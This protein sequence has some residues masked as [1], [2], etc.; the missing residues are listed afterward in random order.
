MKILFFILFF[1]NFAHSK[2]GELSYC[3]GPPQPIAPGPCDTSDLAKCSKTQCLVIESCKGKICFSK[4]RVDKIRLPN[5]CV[6][7]GAP[8]IGGRACC[9]GL[10]ARCGNY[11]AEDEC[12]STRGF[13]ESPGEFSVCINC[14]NKICE[15][16]ENE[17]NCSEDCKPSGVTAKIEFRG[18]DP[19]LSKRPKSQVQTPQGCLERSENTEIL[20]CLDEFKVRLLGHRTWKQIQNIAKQ[21]KFSAL[22]VGVGAC[23]ENVKLSNECL[24][25]LALKHKSLEICSM[26]TDLF[27]DNT[28]HLGTIRKSRPNCYNALE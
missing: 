24:Y 16:N 9:S 6:P 23:L 12:D 26:I 25:D 19:D 13:L 14:G 21:D 15:F 27:T 5:Q 28:A 4:E 11:K 10:K 18:Y 3:P 1:S 2:L 20:H 22:L 17:C 8:T 7:E